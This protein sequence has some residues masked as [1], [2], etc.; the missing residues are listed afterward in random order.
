MEVVANTPP[1]L[2]VPGDLTVEG[3]TTGGW[4]A[5]FSAT[6]SDAEDDPDPTPVCDPAAGAVLPLGTTTIGCS[7]VDAGG[8][9]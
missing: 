9:G 3:D 6:A 4:T 7:V 5:A 8:L 2:T 1:V